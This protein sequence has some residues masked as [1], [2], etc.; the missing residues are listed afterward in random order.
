MLITSLHGIMN[1]TWLW[2]VKKKKDRSNLTIPIVCE[3]EPHFL[4]RYS[5]STFQLTKKRKVCCF[6]FP[7]EVFKNSENG[8]FSDK[9]LI[10]QKNAEF[11]GGKS[12]SNLF[13]D[14]LGYSLNIFGS[15]LGSQRQYSGN[16]TQA[17]IGWQ[18]PWQPWTIITHASYPNDPRNQIAE[19]QCSVLQTFLEWPIP[20]SLL[21]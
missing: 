13:G 9:P 3:F 2:I 20:V 18:L 21:F 15:F 4:I 19:R 1:I 11:L 8:C 16:F 5:L 10:Q 12:N 14:N 6:L 7:E 17:T